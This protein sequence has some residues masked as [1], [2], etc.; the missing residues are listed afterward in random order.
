MDQ[1]L[2]VDLDVDTEF[3]PSV[4]EETPD[5]QSSIQST[6][7]TIEDK[8]REF[9][10]KS[11][12]GRLYWKLNEKANA[13]S[14]AEMEEI[15]QVVVSR[16]HRLIEEG[17]VSEIESVELVNDP[18]DLPTQIRQRICDR[19]T[20]QKEESRVAMLEKKKIDAA[21]AYKNPWLLQH[22]SEMFQYGQKLKICNDATMRSTLSSLLEICENKI[23]QFHES[24]GTTHQEAIEERRKFCLSQG[25]VHQDMVEEIKSV[26]HRLPMVIVDTCMQMTPPS[27]EFGDDTTL[28]DAP[29]TPSWSP[30]YANLVPLTPSWSPKL[31]SPKGPFRLLVP[32]KTPSWSPNP[33]SSKLMEDYT[34]PEMWGGLVPPIPK[35]TQNKRKRASQ[36]AK[37]HGQ[38][39][40]T[41]YFSSQQM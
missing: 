32:P 1:D 36:P 21:Q 15:Q 30:K 3:Q 14:R 27:S 2:D 24:A 17:I 8:M 16:R 39:K 35:R 41:K 23:K 19:N 38:K 37:S 22:E 6:Q 4:P 33:S 18:I 7:S 20:K 40:L 12:R 26:Y 25:Y 29:K 34:S 31:S 13:A 9:H 5:I 11:F 28:G 10:P